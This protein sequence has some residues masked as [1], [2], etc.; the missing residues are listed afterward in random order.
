MSPPIEPPLRLLM[1]TLIAN[2]L[3]PD[4]LSANPLRYFLY[5]Y[6]DKTAPLYNEYQNVSCFTQE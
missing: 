2:V 3:F 1:S 6:F 4:K 5:S